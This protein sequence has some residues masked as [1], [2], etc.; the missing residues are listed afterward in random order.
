[1]KTAK[2]A[3]N[4][5]N[6]TFEDCWSKISYSAEALIDTKPTKSMWHAVIRYLI[7]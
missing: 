4:L 3:N 1:M 5:P 7:I 2:S 6:K